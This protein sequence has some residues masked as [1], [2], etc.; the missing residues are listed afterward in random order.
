MARRNSIL[1][2]RSLYQVGV[3]SLI[4]AVAWVGMGVYLAARQTRAPDVEKSLLEV[5]NPVVDQAVLESLATRLKVSTEMVEEAII[6]PSEASASASESDTI[7]VG[8][9]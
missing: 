2:S 3:M 4:T 7:D 9:V 1:V 5:V 8:G 6:L